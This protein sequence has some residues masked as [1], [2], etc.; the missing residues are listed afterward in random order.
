MDYLPL[1][2]DLRQRRVLLVGGGTVAA[3]KAAWLV[4]AGAHL[5][6]VAPHIDEALQELAAEHDGVELCWRDYEEEDLNQA[7][8]V[9]AGTD[10]SALNRRVA[11]AATALR[12]PVNVVDQPAL[13]SVIFP[14]ILDR[15]PI[16]VAISS[17]ATAPLLVRR[18]K[19][20]IEQL[21]SPRLGALAELLGRYRETVRQRL[22]RAEARLRFWERMVDG[23]V[24]NHALAGRMDEAEALLQENLAEPVEPIQGEVFLVGA[25]PGDPE[26][27]T[28]KALRLMQL[29]DVVLYDRLVSVEVMAQVRQDA[30]R[31]YVGKARNEHAMPQG[32]INQLLV[33]LARRGLRVL[34]LKGG[35]P[36]IFGRGGE[37]IELLAAEGIP[38]QVVPG[39]T[40]ASGCASYA[41]IPLTH[42]DYS[43]SVR[44]VTGHFKDDRIGLP[45]AEL[46]APDQT[47]VVYMGLVG[48]PEI[49]RQL[50][51][52]GRTPDTPI[53]LVEQGTTPRQRVVTGTLDNLPE[54]VAAAGVRA[55]TLLIIGEVVR[56]R[57]NLSWFHGDEDGSRPG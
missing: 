44:F 17:S 27:L 26:L 6:V 51:Q 48:L 38:F 45:W 31:I 37:E 50:I 56:L 36:F 43:H 39:I 53:A 46:A 30:E 34:R 35:D 7:I 3:R 29:A 24:A 18:L 14:A 23:P 11:A 15:S 19:A 12:I 28:L 4:R 22:P 32:D 5:R 8:L 33:D 42:R 52:H 21:L 41:G 16:V 20:Q 54:R 55:P 13:C 25:G 2:F 10:D 47:V 49:C 1:F 57:R 9:V 40:A